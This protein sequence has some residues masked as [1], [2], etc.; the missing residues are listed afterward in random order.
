M[1]S[2][3]MR[4][5]FLALRQATG[6]SCRQ[7]ADYLSVSVGTV[8]RWE[9]GSG[10]PSETAV[11]AFSKLNMELDVQAARLARTTAAKGLPEAILPYW[12]SADDYAARYP[13]APSWAWARDNAI[14]RKAAVLLASRGIQAAYRNG[15]SR[16]SD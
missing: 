5:T 12:T 15:A 4:A 13:Q 7:A 2:R 14:C 1:K 11:D 9:N 10:T 6:F 8:Y 3:D 16:P